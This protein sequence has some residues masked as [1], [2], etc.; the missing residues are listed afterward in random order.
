MSETAATRCVPPNEEAEGEGGELEGGEDEGGEHEGGEDPVAAAG[1][2]K[3]SATA[4][5]E[6]TTYRISLTNSAI[7]DS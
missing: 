4:L 7:K 3:V 1:L 2:D 5:S 6:P